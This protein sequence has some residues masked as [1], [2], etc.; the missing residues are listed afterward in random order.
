MPEYK[1]F[2][3]DYRNLEDCARNKK[4]ARVPLYEHQISDSIIEKVLDVKLSGGDIDDYYK[5]YCDF[6]LKMGYDTVSFEAKI[7]PLLPHGGALTN[8]EPGYID[9]KERLDSYPFGEIKDLF[10]K[11]YDAHFRA[12]EKHM[13]CGM[14]AIGGAG[15]GVF[16]I[17]QDLSGYENLV[18]I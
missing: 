6:Y 16:E 18:F 10:I 13:P 9:S 14:K 7:V 17:A 4:P 11:A 15:Y 8:P 3:P 5:K 1:N 12:L 2:K